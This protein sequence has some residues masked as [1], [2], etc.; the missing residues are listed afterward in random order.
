VTEKGVP[1][2]VPTALTAWHQY[3]PESL[4]RARPIRMLLPRLHIYT[5]PE[6][7]HTRLP[8]VGFL[9][10][11]HLALFLALS[12]SPGLTHGLDGQHQDVDRTLLGRVN[13]NDREQGQMEKV[14]P[15]CGQ[16]SD[17][18]RV[19]KNRTEQGSGADPGSWQSACKYRES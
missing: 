17:R 12:L 9:A 15:W 1:V 19:K 6:P 7:A 4:G 10:F 13:Q 16:P 18:G 14:R 2:A 11:V 3:S 8:S 5:E